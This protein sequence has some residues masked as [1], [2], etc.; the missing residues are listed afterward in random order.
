MAGAEPAG[1]VPHWRPSSKP[2]TALRSQRGRRG[3]G[4]MPWSGSG[5][6][7]SWW[8]RTTTRRE[9]SAWLA[10]AVMVHTCKGMRSWSLPMS[11]ISISAPK[12][13]RRWMLKGRQEEVMTP[14]KQDPHDLASARDL[15]TGECAMAPWPAYNQGL[16]S[17]PPHRA[18]PSR[19]RA[20]GPAYR[21]R[22]GS[23]L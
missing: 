11:W 14:G 5:T 17:D 13:G 4:S 8:P 6:A 20:L 7:P 12:S 16:L 2:T 10:F 1:G 21:C 18:G 3:V 22:G 23:R 15:V 9:L 19:S